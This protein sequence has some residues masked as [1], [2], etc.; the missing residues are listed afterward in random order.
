MLQGADMEWTAQEAQRKDVQD[1]KQLL[2]KLQHCD[3]QPAGHERVPLWRAA[4]A[5]RSA[6]QGIDALQGGNLKVATFLNYVIEEASSGASL[7]P[8]DLLQV[9]NFRL[10]YLKT[11]ALLKAQSIAQQAA[12]TPVQLAADVSASYSDLPDVPTH[13]PEL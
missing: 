9:E 12:A 2:D 4:I 3:R 7:Q 11:S 8:G 10:K 5:L 1:A 6:T 13:R